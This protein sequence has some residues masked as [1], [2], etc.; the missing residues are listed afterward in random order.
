MPE[1]KPRCTACGAPCSS[2]TPTRPHACRMGSDSSSSSTIRTAPLWLMRTDRG[3]PR[4]ARPRPRVRMPGPYQAAAVDRRRCNVEPV[5]DG[6]DPHF[7]YDR[8][9]Q[10]TRRP[11]SWKPQ[12]R[13]AAMALAQGAPSTGSPAR[14]SRSPASTTLP[15]Q[16]T[17]GRPLRRLGRR[18]EASRAYERGALVAR[19][20][21]DRAPTSSA[22]RLYGARSAHCRC[23]ECDVSTSAGEERPCSP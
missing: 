2:R 3:S 7:S 15:V 10:R 14:S 4:R 19:A 6:T 8:L 21:R 11:R 17:L 20:E 1:R 5:V 13:A 9:L 18:E 12:T 22:G 23:A 16:S